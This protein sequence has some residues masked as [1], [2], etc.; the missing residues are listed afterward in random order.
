MLDEDISIVELV[1]FSQ[2]TAAQGGLP[3]SLQ[4][5]VF[6]LRLYDSPM[7]HTWRV[8]KLGIAKRLPPRTAQVVAC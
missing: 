2:P 4:C 3:A 6:N 7:G 1:C 5:L 8:E